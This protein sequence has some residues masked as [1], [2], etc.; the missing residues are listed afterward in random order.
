MLGRVDRVCLW[1]PVMDAKFTLWRVA[2]ECAERGRDG[3]TKR[4]KKSGSRVS[5]PPRV[6]YCL[7]PPI[8]PEKKVQHSREFRGCFALV[9]FLGWIGVRTP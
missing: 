9:F 7:V 8:K 4:T 5:F 2:F 6:A 3:E 1:R